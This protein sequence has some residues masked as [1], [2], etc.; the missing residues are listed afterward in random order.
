MVFEIPEELNVYDLIAVAV[1]EQA[2]QD[3][4]STQPGLAREAGIWLENEGRIWWDI[5]GLEEKLFDRLTGK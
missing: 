4:H 3:A 5:L 2:V 1:I